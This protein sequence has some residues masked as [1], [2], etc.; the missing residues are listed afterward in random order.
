MT[1][2]PVGTGA[3]FLSPPLSPSST[4]TSC[5]CGCWCSGQ[6][7][8]LAGQ[9]GPPPIPWM[10][11]LR[12]RC[13]VSLLNK[14]LSLSLSLSE[15]TSSRI[16]PRAQASC[17]SVCSVLRAPAFPTYELFYLRTGM[18]WDQDGACRCTLMLT[19]HPPYCVVPEHQPPALMIFDL[20]CTFHDREALVL[21]LI[22]I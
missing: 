17:T 20:A 6:S 15:A 14:P 5:P 18:M 10:G 12:H 7:H 2:L 13:S 9:R 8:T 22:H 21:S 16:Q 1:G 11:G 3:R 19:D 4:I